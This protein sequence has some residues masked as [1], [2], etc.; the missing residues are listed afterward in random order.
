MCPLLQ[1][2][3]FSK[4]RWII[5][6]NVCENN[7]Y[8]KDI[9]QPTNQPI[10]KQKHR[11]H[12]RS[13]VVSFPMWRVLFWSLA[14]EKRLMVKGRCVFWD[15]FICFA[16]FFHVVKSSNYTCFSLSTFEN[17][18]FWLNM[19]LFHLAEWF[20]ACFSNKLQQGCRKVSRGT[21]SGPSPMDFH[22]LLLEIVQIVVFFALV[23]VVSTVIICH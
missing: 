15:R 8:M 4:K 2:V 5:T 21:N 14:T 10:W 23:T 19:V 20:L 1:K 16:F 12:F 13:L 18:R 6:Q 22:V 11:I 7:T 17:F 3:L 9:Y